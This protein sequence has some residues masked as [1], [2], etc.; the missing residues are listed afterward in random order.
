MSSDQWFGKLTPATECRAGHGGPGA[1]GSQGSTFLGRSGWLGLTAACT[2]HVGVTKTAQE[3]G[4]KWKG[5][6]DV[7]KRTKMQE[8]IL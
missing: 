8:K 5:F 3:G 1:S 2:G 6:Y 4:E 7:G